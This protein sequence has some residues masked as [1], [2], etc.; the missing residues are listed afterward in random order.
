MHKRDTWK[1]EQRKRSESAGADLSLHGDTHS[2]RTHERY[3]LAAHLI[4]TGYGHWLPND[5]RGR[6]LTSIRKDELEELGPIHHGRK[7]VPPPRDELRNFYRSAT[8]N[9]ITERSGSTPR[10]DK[11]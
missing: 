4:L 2:S 10:R 8:P 1:I 5:P 6:G 9:W 7:K 11:S 3:T